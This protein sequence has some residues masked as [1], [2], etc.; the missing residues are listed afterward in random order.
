MITDFS[1]YEIII[2]AVWAQGFTISG[3]LGV[4]QIKFFFPQKIRKPQY[5]FKARIDF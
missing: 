4:Q 3:S 1:D 5:T 2:K